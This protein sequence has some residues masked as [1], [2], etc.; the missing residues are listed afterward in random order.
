MCVWLWQHTTASTLGMWPVGLQYAQVLLILS[1][2]KHLFLFLW[3]A[4]SPLSFLLPSHKQ[5]LPQYTNG[6]TNKLHSPFP[7]VSCSCGSTQANQHDK[8]KI[9][10][11][12]QYYGL[13]SASAYPSADFSKSMHLDKKKKTQTIFIGISFQKRRK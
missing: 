12:F 13:H 5:V 3:K 10:I 7:R 6:C 9:L 1:L 2:L 4:F 8:E 11:N